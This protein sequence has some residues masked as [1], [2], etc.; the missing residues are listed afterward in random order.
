[1]LAKQTCQEL[2]EEVHYFEKWCKDR[3][4]RVNRP[5]SMNKYGAILDDFGFVQ[6]LDV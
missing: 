2:V 5:N 6:V 1:M 3:Q 4:L